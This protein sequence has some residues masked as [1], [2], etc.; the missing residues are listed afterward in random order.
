M[1]APRRAVTRPSPSSPDLRPRTL[2]DLR[3]DLEG[4]LAMTSAADLPTP[5]APDPLP[6]LVVLDM[7]GTT[8]DDRDEVYRVLREAVQREGARVDDTT[9]QRWMGTEKRAAI[10]HLLDVGGIDPDDELV[11]TA[12]A[13]FLTELA[14]T[15][16][17]APPVPLPGV[18][19]ALRALRDAGIAIALT[20]GFSRD[21]ADMILGRMGWEVGPD[22]LL[23]AVVCGDEVPAGRPAP[24]MI[25]AAMA[26]TGVEDPAAVLSAGDT[27]VDI[28]SARA[29][30]ATAV[31]VLTGHLSREDVLAEGA[32]LVLDSVADLP[33]RLGLGARA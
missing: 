32:D 33:G 10:T 17:E 14:R 23:D 15:Y 21:I 8:V 7:A 11:E 20:T 4:T 22:E 29:A 25:R 6:R 5:P 13:W 26:I 2:P 31:G 30:G 12:F 28:A 16:T 18:E 9:F 24:D 19:Q 27:A 3:P 1:A